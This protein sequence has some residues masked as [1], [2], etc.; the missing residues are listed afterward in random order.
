MPDAAAPAGYSFAS[1]AAILQTAE[2]KLRYWAQTGLVGP[3]LRANGKALFSFRD[4]VSVKAAKELTDRGF[5]AADI[6]RALVA[7]REHLPTLEHPLDRLRVAFDGDSLVVL[8]EGAVFEPTGQRVF[9]FGVAE[10]A[11]RASAVTAAEPPPAPVIPA[12]R[13][14]T[15]PAG[16]RERARAPSPP[17]AAPDAHPRSAYEWFLEGL[18]RGADALTREDAITAY[19]KALALD[20]GL[21]A[22]RT[23]LGILLYQRGEVD[24]ARAEFEAALAGDPEQ[25]EARFNLGNLLLERGDV[26]VAAAELR[27]VLAL[28]PDFADAH[29]NLATALERL[30]SRAQAREHLERYLALSG[31]TEAD[32]WAAEARAR[33]ERL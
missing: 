26:E 25:A 19:R 21:A 28:A 16:G 12:V 9:D 29:F 8:T 24:A 17:T 15:P 18:R 14:P 32:P 5:R 23:N 33:L 7:A 30:G 20:P 11:E 27:R 10:L 31:G 3:S 4:L 6:R 1:V 13:A 22:A 2:S